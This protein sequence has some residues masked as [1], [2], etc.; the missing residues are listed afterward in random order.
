M[1][2]QWQERGGL[3]LGQRAAQ[4]VDQILQEHQPE[5]LPADVKQRLS[6]IVARTTS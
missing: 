6:E 4:R 3:T 1:Y 2:H 5:E